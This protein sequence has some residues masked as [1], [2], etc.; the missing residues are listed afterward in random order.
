[1]VLK[2]YMC[3]KNILYVSDIYVIFIGHGDLSY[4]ST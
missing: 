2:R 4:I 3:S 1:M